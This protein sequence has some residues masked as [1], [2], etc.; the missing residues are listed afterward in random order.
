[1]PFAEFTPSA[2]GLQVNEQSLRAADLNASFMERA[3]RMRVNDF[4]LERSKQLLSGELAL[5]NT[6]VQQQNLRVDQMRNELK[7]QENALDVQSHTMEAQRLAGDNEA[8]HQ[9]AIADGR[10]ANSKLIAQL[11]GELNALQNISP[12][13]RQGYVKAWSNIQAKYDHLAGDPFYG[14]QYHTAMAPAMGEASMRNTSFQLMV[15]DAA[16]HLSAKVARAKSSQDLGAVDQD[17]MYAY[18]RQADPNFVKSFD[19]RMKQL[20]ELEVKTR[21]AEVARAKQDRELGVGAV[22]KL[23]GNATTQNYNKASAAFDD[24]KSAYEKQTP[25]RYSD[26]AALTGYF[27]IIDPTMG[28]N[29]SQEEIFNH[30]QNRKDRW[31]AEFRSLYTNEGGSLSPES[32]KQLFEAAQMAH[33]SQAAQYGLVSR[34]YQRGLDAAG[35]QGDYLPKPKE[36]SGGMNSLKVGQTASIR[37]SNGKTLQG[38]VREKGG[39]HYV[40]DSNGNGYPIQNQK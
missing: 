32:R 4:Q 6:N 33:S 18:V 31:A 34:E 12:D 11:P 20:N 7:Q 5:Q 25:T 38:T 8:A 27:K 16:A 15:Q 3:Q 40:V 30:L 9:K 22:D 35:V 23:Q 21:E 37:L 2:V 13:D 24:V 14:Q 36:S 26:M 19:E 29:A 10:V 39:V 17:P 1:M 28:F